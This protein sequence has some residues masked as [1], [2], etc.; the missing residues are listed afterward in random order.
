LNI[1]LFVTDPVLL[2]SVFHKSAKLSSG[3][4][5]AAGAAGGFG[6]FAGTIPFPGAAGFGGVAGIFPGPVAGAALAGAA[7][8]VGLAT[9]TVCTFLNISIILMIYYS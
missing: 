3:D 7:G 4:T 2:V 5:G 8:V 1:G 9:V 6:V